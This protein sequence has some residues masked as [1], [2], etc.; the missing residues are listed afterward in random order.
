MAMH[1]YY[2][3]WR[4]SFFALSISL[5]LSACECVALANCIC[6]CNC[7]EWMGSSL[8]ILYIA[9]VAKEATA[10]A[11]ANR[12]STNDANGFEPSN[13]RTNEQTKN[14]RI[15]Y[16]GWYFMHMFMAYNIIIGVHNYFWIPR[17]LQQSENFTR[18]I[19]FAV[20]IHAAVRTRTLHTVA[21]VSLQIID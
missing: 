3:H 8:A 16:F 15:L 20:S 19:G 11:A 17:F 13:E 7:N 9:T 14:S 12:H 21:A 6:N 5:S 4:V 1:Y 10:A 18:L 2:N